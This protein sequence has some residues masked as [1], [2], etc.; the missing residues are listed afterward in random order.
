MNEGRDDVWSVSARDLDLFERVLIPANGISFS[1]V[2][3]RLVF[4]R[5]IV[6]VDRIV[7]RLRLKKEV[8]EKTDI[9]PSSEGQK[10][11]I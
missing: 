11:A 1:S 4:L 5:P 9:V 3:P 7:R 10:L 2:R 6:V 8:W